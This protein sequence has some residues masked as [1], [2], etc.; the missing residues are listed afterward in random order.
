[1]TAGS[2]STLTVNAGTAAPGTYPLTVTGT[3]SSATHSTPISLTITG[4]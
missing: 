3:G 4:P 1:V 2:S